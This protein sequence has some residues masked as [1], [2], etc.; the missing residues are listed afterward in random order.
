MS[1]LV[2][3]VVPAYNAESRIR[4]CLESIASQDYGDIEIIAV[5]DASTDRTGEIVREVLEGAGRKFTVITHESNSGVSAARNTGM[6][7][8]T[9][10]YVCFVD[11]DDVIRKNFVSLLH[12]V[13]SEQA[14]D[15]AFCGLHDAFQDA[16]KN[17]DIPYAHGESRVLNGEEILAGMNNI[18]ASVCCM[19][20][21]DFLEKYGLR[22]YA[23][24]PAGE[25]T[26]FI[27]KALCRAVRVTF[28]AKCLY[29]YVHH[30]EMGSV[31]DNDTRAKRI[32]RYEHNTQAQLR[33]AEYLYK[34][35]ESQAL[36]DL[37]CKVL[38]PQVMVRR[39]NLAAVKNDRRSYNALLADA[40]TVKVL[41]SATGL[42]TFRR[43]PEVFIKA[44]VIRCLPD[45]YF[46]MRAKA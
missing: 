11:G 32:L 7:A 9:G 2:S 17:R 25:D 19:Y 8:S 34:Y 3:V 30:D 15:I 35:A 39:L 46:R 40:D 4:P 20:R 13:I 42:Y 38:M 31:R 24:C 33:T 43:K 6:A 44:L 37:V 14:C 41:R 29:V 28:T 10:E 16:G 12:E 36:R 45:L 1:D 5:D 18:P 26:E 23:G 27:T 22:Y 21:R